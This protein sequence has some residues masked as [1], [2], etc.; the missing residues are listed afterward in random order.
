MKAYSS[1]LRR[2]YRRSA[3][4]LTQVPVRTMAGGGKIHKID[5]N[6]TNFDICVVGGLNATALTK[7]LQNEHKGWKIALISERSKFVCPELYFLCS[8]SA[9]KVLKL[10]SGSVG[11]QVD[12]SS[13]VEVGVRATKV[14]PDKN[15]IELST[16][17]KFTY[18]SLVY[19]PGFDHSVNNIKG[20]SEFEKEGDRTNVYSHIVDN[21]ARTDRNYYHGWE[22]Y[23]GDY[24]VYDPAR[25]YKSEGSSF[26]P[27]YYE[28][29]LRQDLLHGRASKNARIQYWTP[30]KKIF[31]FPFANEVA[32]EECH[33]R[34]IDVYLGWELIEVKYNE[35]REKIGVF[36]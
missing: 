30:N 12:A 35:A 29:I 1:I 3:Q 13:R 25:P 15:E 6:E 20:L 24:I 31:D 11:S 19:A 28:Y 27:L 33:K 9:I 22:H 21:V 7:F 16:G 4:S 34:G 14:N 10:E 26:Y 23:G 8:H 2:A 5:K 18:K 32:L 17:K 36:K